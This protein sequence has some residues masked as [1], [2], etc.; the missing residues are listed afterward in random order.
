MKGNGKLKPILKVLVNTFYREKKYKVKMHLYKCN[1][2]DYVSY[3]SCDI[4]KHVL[5]N[6]YHKYNYES[7]CL[8]LNKCK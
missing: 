7:I 5:R 2:C 8:R 4:I 1:K 6:K 3:R